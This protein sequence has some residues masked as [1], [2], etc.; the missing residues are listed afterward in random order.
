MPRVLKMPIIGRDPTT[1]RIAKQD[2]AERFWAYVVKE[3]PVMKESLGRCWIWIGAIFKDKG[4][5]QFQNRSAHSFSY[6][7]HNGP[8][9]SGKQLD[10]LCRIRC[11]VNPHHLEPVTIRENLARGKS[12]LHKGMFKEKQFCKKGHLLA[13]TRD[14]RSECG[15][16]SNARKR[17]WELAKGRSSANQSKAF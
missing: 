13:K 5:G 16:C 10:H 4:Y 2:K 9:P 7:L 8:V 1:G 12:W 3:G 6:Q 17:R 15:I 11:C 14:K